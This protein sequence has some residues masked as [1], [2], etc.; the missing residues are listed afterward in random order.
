L[1]GLILSVL[2][3]RLWVAA[4]LPLTEDESYYRLWAQAP[5]LGYFDHPPMIAWWIWLGRRLI[6]DTPLGVRLVPCLSSAAASF[7]VFDLA[8]ALGAPR[9]AAL[10]GVVW[11]NA[12]LLVAAGAMLA[13]PDS[14]AALF[15]LA[16]LCCI[17]RA[18]KE[19]SYQWWLGAGTA[20]GL[21]ALSKYS[22][23]FLGPGV[24]IWLLLRPEGRAALLR[25]GP[26]LALTVALAI[27]SLNI[28]WNAEHQWLTFDKQFSRI[29]PHH[30]APWDL[31][32]LVITQTFLLNPLIALFLAFAVAR[33]PA[34]PRYDLLLLSS[35]PFLAYLGLHAL[36][37]RV[38]AHWPAPLYGPLALFAALASGDGPRSA[39]WDRLRRLV[40]G[41]AVVACLLAFGLFLLPDIGVPLAL[42]P[43][44]PL[45][46]WRGFSLR[47]NQVT[48]RQDARWIGTT[49]YGLAAVLLDQ[50]TIET[51]VLQVT[52]RDRWRDLRPSGADLSKPGLIVDLQRRMNWTVLGACFRRV[53]P[54]GTLSRAA[55]GERGLIYMVVRVEGPREDL[56]RTGCP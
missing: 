54:I 22:A 16:S 18:R 40:P 30:L 2:A 52:E 38:Q 53:E 19:S 8:R 31:A 1:A 10:R 44:K 28:G 23:L 29:T 34:H 15:W 36:H 51:P 21:A 43:G 35:L 20:A 50:E 55:P 56:V 46:D 24:L 32:D 37:G 42:D 6:G 45:R 47:L 48:A 11:Y 12:T 25:P 7:L 14:P 5:A 17:A 41:V 27:F 4:T 33:A 3:L 26:W 9:Q 49:S 13:V 39:P